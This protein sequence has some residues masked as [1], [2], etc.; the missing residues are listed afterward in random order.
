MIEVE[1][2]AELALIATG[3]ELSLALEWKRMQNTLVVC[4]LA[5]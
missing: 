5:H 1:V 3:S 2:F 4:A